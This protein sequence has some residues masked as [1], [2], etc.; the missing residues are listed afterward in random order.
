MNL[1]ETKVYSINDFLQWDDNQE[2]VLSPK[3]QRKAVW[4]EKAQSYLIDTI[5]RG[6]PIPQVFVRQKIDTQLRKTTR[7]IIDGQ[8]RLRAILK[9][10]KDE[11]PIM[12]IHNPELAG[13]VYSDLNE[14]EKMSFLDY[15]IPVELI[16]SSDDNVIY[17]MFM[18]VNTNSVTLNRQELRNAKYWGDL[19]VLAYRLSSD[20]RSFFEE[21]RIFSDAQFIRMLDV[22]FVSRLLRIIIEGVKTD[23][24]KALDDFYGKY[25][26]LENLDEIDRKFNNVCERIQK[27]FVNE[28]FSTNYFD[29]PNYFF[30]LFCFIFDYEYGIVNFEKEYNG[31]TNFD[32]GSLITDLNNL[33]SYLDQDDSNSKFQKFVDFHKVRTTNEKERTIRIDMLSQYLYDGAFE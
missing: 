7:E 17:D 1:K 28:L 3:Y 8:Q 18:R 33:E 4:N 15:Q 6:L 9:F 30:T 24:P 19:K 20:W 26:N 27:L 2:L 21:Y 16:K 25:E 13:K 31:K 29:K 32:Y 14:D 10:Y 5:I 22:E 23:T 11:L 12:R